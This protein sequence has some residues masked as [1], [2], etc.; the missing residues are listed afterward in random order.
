MVS[1]PLLCTSVYVHTNT[2]M[3]PISLE[4]RPRASAKNEISCFLPVSQ[5]TQSFD[6]EK[7][8]LVTPKF[9]FISCRY[10]FPS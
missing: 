6:E 7:R 3:D 8:K 9:G 1:L 10:S 2:F 5:N 4:I